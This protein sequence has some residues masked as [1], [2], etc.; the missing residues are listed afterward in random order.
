MKKIRVQLAAMFVLGLASLGVFV[1]AAYKNY[2]IGT[3]ASDTNTTGGGD[4]LA[5]VLLPASFAVLLVVVIGLLVMLTRRL[6]RGRLGAMH[7]NISQSENA[8]GEAIPR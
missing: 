7:P 8:T 2:E 3:R 1:W 6:E 4:Q 5:L